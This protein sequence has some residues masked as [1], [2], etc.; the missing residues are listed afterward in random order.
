MDDFIA[1]PMNVAALYATL[2]R[3]LDESRAAAGA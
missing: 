1:K 2:L 3:W